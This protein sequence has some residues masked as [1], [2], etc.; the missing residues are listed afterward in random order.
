MSSKQWGLTHSC[1]VLEEENVKNKIA[2]I[3]QW[4][5]SRPPGS[6]YQLASILLQYR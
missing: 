6:Q 2:N 1:S 4:G 5:L 3:R